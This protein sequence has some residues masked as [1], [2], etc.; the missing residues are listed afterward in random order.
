M[1]AREGMQTTNA[2]DA[3]TEVNYCGADGLSVPH[4]QQFLLT[5]CKQTMLP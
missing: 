4:C 1:I 3:L 2:Q 5:P